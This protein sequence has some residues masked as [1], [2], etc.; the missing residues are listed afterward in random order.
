VGEVL[1][2]DFMEVEV[3]FAAVEEGDPVEAEVREVTAKLRALFPIYSFRKW[4]S[5]GRRDER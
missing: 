3:D 5:T 4:G 1:L 2:E